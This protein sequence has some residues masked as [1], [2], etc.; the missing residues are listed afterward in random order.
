MEAK[1]INY[2]IL[3]DKL[4]TLYENGFGEELQRAGV[5][6]DIGVFTVELLGY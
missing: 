4:K 2:D 5:L 3:E 6:I 1:T